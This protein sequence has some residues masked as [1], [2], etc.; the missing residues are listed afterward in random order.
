VTGSTVAITGIGILT[1]LGDELGSIGAALAEGRRS[2]GP[3]VDLPEVGESRFAEFEATRYAN[4]RGMRLYNRTTRLGICATKLALADA[5]LDG[6]SLPGAGLGL[7]LASTYAHLDTAI[8][9][10]RS[11]VVSGI[12]Q[13]NPALMPLAIP[14]AP[15]ATLALAFGAKAASITLAN[16]AASG[17]DALGLGMRLVSAGRAAACVV[18]GA[19]A[20]CRELA[21][22]SA[23]A[24]KLVPAD[25]LHVFDARHRGTVYGEA[26]AALV[27]ESPDAARGRGVVPKGILRGHGAA[28]SPAREGVAAL[29]RACH[30]ALA[31]A[32]VVPSDLACV[33]SGANGRPETDD[34]E[35]QALLALL[36]PGSRAA[37]T[38][39]KSSL[40]DMVDA[41]GLVQ[42]A[43]ALESLRS[44]RAPAVVGLERPA[45]E[46]LTYATTVT[47]LSGD[48]A[49]VT[50]TNE[51]GACSAIV[52]QNG[53]GLR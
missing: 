45:L 1:P 23:R 16:D 20:A 11:L 40:G 27:L 13:T 31:A 46:G 42:A 9:Y 33:S 30:A 32:D 24:G 34:A 15:G 10:D 38:A 19:F 51:Q 18:V 35:A 22:S 28:F 12:Q 44:G 39:V 49:L 52:L 17:L 21:Q 2:I 47:A 3:A 25:E 5:G 48:L 14:S 41:G 4:V 36:G 43:L 8:E 7:V 29:G 50:A 37:V 53:N 6:V 26:S